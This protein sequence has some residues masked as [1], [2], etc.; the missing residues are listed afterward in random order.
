MC[1]AEHLKALPQILKPRSD[2]ISDASPDA[3]VHLVEDKRLRSGR[4]QIEHRTWF[5]VGQRFQREH[6]PRQLAARHNP[7]ER[8]KFLARI[9]GNEKFRVVDTPLTPARLGK[10]ALVESHLET[11]PRHREFVQ[12]YFHVACEA[13][14][15]RTAS[16]RQ[17]SCLRQ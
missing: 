14:R 16:S 13:R 12:Q 8:P 10:L 4:V 1:D 7:R 3:G 15:S 9:R 2:A 6:Y 11:R 5:R 17:L